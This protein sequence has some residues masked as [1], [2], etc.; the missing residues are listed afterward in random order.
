MLKFFVVYILTIMINLLKRYTSPFNL[1][2]FMGFI[3]L[4]QSLR[5]SPNLQMNFPNLQMKNLYYLINSIHPDNAL[6]FLVYLLMVL[7]TMG[8]F[9][10]T[11]QINLFD[12]HP[13]FLF[14]YYLNLFLLHLMLY[15]FLK[16]LLLYLLMFFII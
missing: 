10:V 11:L 4:L 5:Y 15:S 6:H 8:C 1:K 16:H 13:Y 7:I 9:L 2:S 12:Q 14:A 3:S